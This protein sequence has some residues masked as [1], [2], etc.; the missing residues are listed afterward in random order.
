VEAHFDLP[1]RWCAAQIGDLGRRVIDQKRIAFERRRERLIR[2]ID[3]A[4]E[5]V[6]RIT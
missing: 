3:G 1:P 4:S 2:R 6:T 5:A